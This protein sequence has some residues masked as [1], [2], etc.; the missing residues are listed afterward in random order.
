M[1]H[2]TINTPTLLLTA[3]SVIGCSDS[4]DGD[5]LRS[6]AINDAIRAVPDLVEPDER[7]E[8]E[9]LNTYTT[10]IGTTV[11]DCTRYR[12]DYAGSS[13]SSNALDGMGDVIYPGADVQL[14][15]MT[16]FSPDPVTAPRGAGRLVMVNEQNTTLPAVEVPTVNLL[17]VSEA[18]NEMVAQHS[19]VLTANTRFSINQVRAIEELQLSLNA[20]ASFFGVFNASAAFSLEQGEE[21]SAFLVSLRQEMYTIAFE[22]PDTPSEFYGPNVTA[23]DLE[24]AMGVG[25][26]LG[27]VSRV[28]Y[29]R[30]FHLLIQTTSRA[31]EMNAALSANFFSGELDGEGRYFTG[32]E[33]VSVNVFAYGGNQSHVVDSVT[34]GLSSLNAF[35]GELNAGGD[36]TTTKPILWTVRSIGTDTLMRNAFAAGYEYVECN[37][38]G[39]LCNVSLQHPHSG[40]EHDNGCRHTPNPIQWPFRWQGCSTADRYQIQVRHNV[41]GMYRDQETVNDQ[42]TLTIPSNEAFLEPPLWTGWSWRVR[43]RSFGTWGGWASWRTFRVEPIDHDC[44]QT[45]VHVYARRNYE[46]DNRLFNGDIPDLEDYGLADTISSL[47]FNNIRGVRLWDHE[48]Y[49]GRNIEIF[50]VHGD[51]PHIG[52]AHPSWEDDAEAL[53]IIR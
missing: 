21:W 23:A 26:P 51:I 27:Y 25:N 30:V 36:I 37:E 12:H 7:D 49:T 6:R 13:E 52:N 40:G 44:L 18:I 35:V 10:T 38:A 29:G 41:L 24:N 20:S 11:V 9:E 22:R 17:T 53:Q 50:A 39:S 45:G 46:G 14:G 15:S 5:D 19:G 31:S 1:K 47:T 8:L 43:A 28:E 32:L 42:I 48:N 2:H 4:S 3:L 33:N 16:N 34:G